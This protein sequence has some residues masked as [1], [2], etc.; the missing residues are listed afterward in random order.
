MSEQSTHYPIDL[1]IPVTIDSQNGQIEIFGKEPPRFKKYSVGIAKT[2][3]ILGLYNQATN[4]GLFEYTS[5][6][7][8]FNDIRANISQFGYQ[9]ATIFSQE[10]HNSI[11]GRVV[12]DIF[13]NQNQ[14]NRP[15]NTEYTSLADF[16][17]SYI[18]FSV[19][20]DPQSTYNI[21]NQSDII[22]RINDT[23]NISSY[24]W[25]KPANTSSP[26]GDIAIRIMQK[27]FELSRDRGQ[28]HD[29][30][31]IMMNQI[32][33][34][35]PTRFLSNTESKW[36]PL[37]FY[38]DDKIT[39]NIIFKNFTFNIANTYTTYYDENNPELDDT[40][41]GKINR[42]IFSLVFT[43]GQNKGDYTEKDLSK[44]YTS[45]YNEGKNGK[46]HRM[47][48][49]HTI[50]Y[51]KYIEGYNLGA[52][53]STGYKSALKGNIIPDTSPYD[54]QELI[55]EYL[56]GFNSAKHVVY[57][58]WG[59]QISQIADNNS[60][61]VTDNLNNIY[62][63][64]K[65]HKNIKD[66]KKYSVNNI[67][68]G[69]TEPTEPTEHIES[70]AENNSI[71]PTSL[72]LLKYDKNGNYNW[73]L[74][75]D[76]ASSLQEE[77]CTI[78]SVIFD[79][80]QNMYISAT[81]N[82]ST[83]INKSYLTIRKINKES[84]ED[85]IL[86][87]LAENMHSSLFL[88]KNSTTGIIIKFRQDSTI[89]WIGTIDGADNDQINQIATDIY[90]NVY[91]SASVRTNSI[92]STMVKYRLCRHPNT[93]NTITT[94]NMSSFGIASSINTQALLLKLKPDG[95]VI[96][97]IKADGSSE[98]F[99]K[100]I[101]IDTDNNIYWSG[102]YTNSLSDINAFRLYSTN[103]KVTTL[104]GNSSTSSTDLFMSKYTPEGILVWATKIGSTSNDDEFSKNMV[105]DSQNNILVACNMPSASNPT[106]IAGYL[107]KYTPQEGRIA[108]ISTITGTETVKI[109]T[110]AIDS[111]DGI[112]VGLYFNEP[113]TDSSNKYKYNILNSQGKKMADI[114]GYNNTLQRDAFYV[115]FKPDGTYDWQ[116]RV[117]A[118][119][120]SQSYHNYHT[121]DKE[122]NIILTNINSKS[123]ATEYSI[124]Y[125]D[126][127]HCIYNSITHPWFVNKVDTTSLNDSIKLIKILTDGNASSID[128]TIPYKDGFNSGKA[129][130]TSKNNYYTTEL[131]LQYTNGF[132]D[133]QAYRAGYT[134]AINRNILSSIPF[135]E[136]TQKSKYDAYVKGT[137]D[138]QIILNNP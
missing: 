8:S 97:S 44:A 95:S 132:G 74:S 16:I 68:T 37:Q 31:K 77:M 122:N 34:Q 114:I 1:V 28:E 94:D 105:L 96:W 110:I 106:K 52:S 60:I 111:T 130:Q 22:S 45:G 17:I 102:S 67:L 12:T 75:I 26:S 13:T 71:I 43:I 62:I 121:I 125:A 6:S 131:Q 100:N 2:L 11:T 27:I 73:T 116:I 65:T 72:V 39:L 79:N 119:D 42:A 9:L 85:T 129:G 127:T 115:R 46:A 88:G 23:H 18:A 10:L 5:M 15:E 90:N 91:I 51:N 47:Y 36:V 3:H 56:T 120:C 117:S 69:P 7:S 64:G 41:V 38:P 21:I 104:A 76:T 33:Q 135:N 35:D 108:W 84:A 136:I 14:E 49:T 58:A 101:L 30:M 81:I 109:G 48:S 50:V 40:I 133:G 25:S 124:K 92:N 55:D 118:V 112:I 54:T 128:Y 24:L 4:E 20:G 138:G 32:K 29:K 87:S 53:F 86:Y 19:F 89:D 93:E 99:G 103:K 66:I 57:H 134:N 80:S 123:S 61:I 107:I 98:D 137:Q 82:A 70:T 59:V 126:S 78:T 113:T 63:T 83:A